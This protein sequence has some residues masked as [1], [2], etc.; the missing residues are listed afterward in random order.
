MNS[1][2]KDKIFYVIVLLIVGS[3]A[4]FWAGPIL[5]NRYEARKVDQQIKAFIEK[6]PA[7]QKKITI[8]SS[9]TSPTYY[10]LIHVKEEREFNKIKEQI[11]SIVFDIS[12]LQFKHEKVIF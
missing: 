5:E 1:D 10:I 4:V 7:L 8:R 6:N 12:L 11:K 3:I 9:P 2:N